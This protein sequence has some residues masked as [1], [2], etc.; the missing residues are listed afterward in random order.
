MDQGKVV[1]KMFEDRV[2][3]NKPFA[4]GYEKYEPIAAAIIKAPGQNYTE[5][6]M[7][8]TQAMTPTGWFA[9]DAWCRVQVDIMKKNGKFGWAGDWKTGK[10]DFDEHQLDLTAAVAMTIDQELEQFST[11]FIWLRDG[12][13]NGQKY[14]RDQLPVLWSKLLVEP[15]RMQEYNT[16]N[17]W[18]ARPSY[19]CAYCP[20]NKLGK[21]SSAGTA[22]KGG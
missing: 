16:M 17:N 1:H 21:C 2:A 20:V 12:I 19:K 18:P 10:V 5:Y 14:T 6:Q 13:I 11:S 22:Y 8:L 15:T 4:H 7:T 3:L 9:K